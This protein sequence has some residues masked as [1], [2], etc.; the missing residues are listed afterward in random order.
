VDFLLSRFSPRGR[1]LLN[2]TAMLTLAAMTILATYRA[3]DVLTESRALLST[4]STPMATP[5]W[6][7]QSIWFGAWALFSLTALIAARHAFRLLLARNWDEINKRYGPQTLQEEIE[8][9]SAVHLK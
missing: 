1:A 5:L 8:S 4:A 6:W 9:E 2:A 3:W 7:P